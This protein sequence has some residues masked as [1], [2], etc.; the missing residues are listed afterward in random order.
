MLNLKN[1]TFWCLLLLPFLTFAQSENASIIKIE[2]KPVNPK[3]GFTIAIYKTDKDIKI[4]FSSIDSIGKVALP[5]QDLQAINRLVAKNNL[6]SL[7]KDSLYHFQLKLDSVQKAHT[8]YKKDSTTVYKSTHKA[9]WQDVETIFKTP[10]QVLTKKQ[11]QREVQDGTYCFF[12][13]I[14]NKDQQD[15]YLFIENLDPK[16]YPQLVKLVNDTKTII[17]AYQL[18]MKRKNQ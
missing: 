4:F 3:D 13:I 2:T 5:A 10:D 8:A 15:R 16:I 6:D 12:T 9:Y 14:Q 18:V 17:A 11:E 1:I 7:E